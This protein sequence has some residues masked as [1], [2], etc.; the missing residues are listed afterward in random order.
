[1]NRK[2]TNTIRFVMDECIPPFIRDNKW[3]MYPFYYLAYRGKNISEVMNFKQR[4]YQF[5]EADYANFYNQIDSISRNRLTDLNAAS[6]EFI[7]TQIELIQPKKIVDIGCG[8]GYLLSLI[9]ERFPEIEL[10]GLDI[11]ACHPNPPYTFVQGNIENLPFENNSFDLV[12]CNHT[13]EH[14][15]HLSTCI[16]E[17]IRVTKSNLLVVTPKQRYFY[18]TLD[19]HVN[20]FYQA[21]QLTSLFPI[22]NYSIKNLQGDWGYIGIVNPT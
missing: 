17:L 6:I 1:M 5:S 15:I 12:L 8:R 19:E 3:F 16:H 13:I 20:F 21:E 22:K 4:V 10:T 18:Y 2:F 14:L 9:H 11:K 7:F